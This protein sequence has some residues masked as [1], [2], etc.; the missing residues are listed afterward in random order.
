MPHRVPIERGTCRARQGS[1]ARFRHG[2]QRLARAGPGDPKHGLS[3]RDDLSRLPFDRYD[4]AGGFGD[5]SPVA[6]L[7]RRLSRDRSEPIGL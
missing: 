4:Y 5:E 6:C 7:V 1:A 3:R 2:D